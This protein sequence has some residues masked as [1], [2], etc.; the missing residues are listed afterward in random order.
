MTITPVFQVAIFASAC[1]LRKIKNV[2]CE[3]K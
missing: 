3:T 2:Q 1:V